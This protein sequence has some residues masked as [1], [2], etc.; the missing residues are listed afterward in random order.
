MCPKSLAMA[1]ES[2]RM[3]TIGRKIDPQMDA[4]ERG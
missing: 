3:K 4:D 1:D 2:A